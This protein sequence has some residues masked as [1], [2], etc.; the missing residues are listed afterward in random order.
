[1]TGW[2]WLSEQETISDQPPR[3]LAIETFQEGEGQ[4]NGVLE[5]TPG[6]LTL[7]ANSVQRAQKRPGD[8]GNAAAWSGWPGPELV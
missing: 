1:M 8:A 2:V 4:L 7:S 5:L 6:V 3:G